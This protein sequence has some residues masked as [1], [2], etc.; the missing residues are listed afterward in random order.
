MEKSNNIYV[1]P[2]DFGWDDVGSWTSLE[3]YRQKDEMGN[4]SNQNCVAMDSK[5]NI[6]M[7]NKKVILNGVEDIIVVETDDYIMISSKEKAQE[8]KEIKKILEC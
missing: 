6:I 8:I 1:I 2:C 7:A 3:R 5:G 4:I